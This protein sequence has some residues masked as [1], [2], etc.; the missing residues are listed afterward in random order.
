MIA[1]EIKEQVLFRSQLGVIEQ[2]ARG[3]AVRSRLPL[4]LGGAVVV[5]TMVEV[6]ETVVEPVWGLRHDMV[7][8]S[9]W[10]CTLTCVLEL[11]FCSCEHAFV[12]HS[13]VGK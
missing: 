6:I 9:F 13:R 1:G 2:C 10:L 7:F 5:G 8:V 12:G 4:A 11:Q 3:C